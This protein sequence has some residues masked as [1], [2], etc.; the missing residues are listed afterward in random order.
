MKNAKRSWVALGV[1]IVI[2]LVGL[3]L[4]HVYHLP[5]RRIPVLLR[6]WLRLAGAQGPLLIIVLYL[7]RMVIVVIPAS[8]I[9]ILA[10]TLYGP[11]VGM[12]L[13]MV[14]ENVSATIAFWV[15]RLI[16]RKDIVA[17]T[18][19]WIRKMDDV[20][21][22]HGFYS[23]LSLRVFFVPFDVINVI[24]GVSSVSY[25]SFALATF[26]GLLPSIFALSFG[27]EVF[28]NTDS[29]LIIGVSIIVLYATLLIVRRHPAVMRMLG[30]K[31]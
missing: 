11:W 7:L 17:S 2:V 3:W 25:R 5:F 10:A 13:A 8:M 31:V 30:E 18:R 16:G 28:Q 22:E 15:A 12:F 21:D 24:G 26:F 29:S 9:N 1:W 4:M 14:G 6:H 19:S 20:I 27:G 23:I